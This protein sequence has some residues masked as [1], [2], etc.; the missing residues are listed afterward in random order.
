M[1]HDGIVHSDQA[2]NASIEPAALQVLMTVWLQS[3]AGK[4]LE[5]ELVDLSS[6]GK[7]SEGRPAAAQSL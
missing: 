2:G 1:A 4:L 3:G 6:N 7:H 5:E